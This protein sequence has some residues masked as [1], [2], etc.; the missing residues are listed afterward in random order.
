M[1]YLPHIV[2]GIVVVCFIAYIVYSINKKGIKKAALDW[3]VL[4]EEEF[5]KGENQAKFEYVYQAVYNILPAYIKVFVSEQVAKNF[6]SKLIQEIFD[7][8]K[9]ALDCGVKTKNEEEL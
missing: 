1:E 3:I 7:F 9:P 5:Q 2:I 6:L 4:A 8:V